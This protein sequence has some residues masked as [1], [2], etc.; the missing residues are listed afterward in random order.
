MNTFL[1]VDSVALKT[2]NRFVL[3]GVVREGIVVAGMHV[4]HPSLTEDAGLEIMKAD[5]IEQGATAAE[6]HI[7]LL[8]RLDDVVDSGLNKKELWIGKEIR[9]C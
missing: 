7:A 1:V 9:C 4:F 8:L 3:T 5:L 6:H 2:T